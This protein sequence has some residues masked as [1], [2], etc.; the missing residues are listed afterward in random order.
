[1]T[2]EANASGLNNDCRKHLMLLKLAGLVASYFSLI[3][4]TVLQAL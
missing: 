2:V 1:M 3:V 4:T